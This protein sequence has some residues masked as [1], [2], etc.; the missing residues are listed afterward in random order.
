V[1]CVCMYCVSFLTSIFLGLLE[2]ETFDKVIKKEGNF[3][4]S[5]FGGFMK[6]ERFDHGKNKVG[7]S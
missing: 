4:A 2:S 7:D 5:K 6:R 3:F 1:L